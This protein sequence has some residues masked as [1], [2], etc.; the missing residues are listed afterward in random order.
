MK[1]IMS[2]RYTLFVLAFALSF[3]TAQA[4]YPEFSTTIPNGGQKGTELKLTVT[5]KNLEDF[6]SLMFFSPGFTQKSTD[7][8]EK[9]KVQVTIAIAADVPSGNHLIRIRTK[10]GISHGRRLFVGPF[11]NVEEKEPNTEFEAAQVIQLNQT[12][13]GV[14][15][16]EDVDYYKVTVKKGQRISVE[17]D[18]LCLGYT[19][20]DPYIAIIDKDRFEKAFSDDTILHRQDG[21]CSFV[22]E[23]DGDYYVMMR[24]S[25]YRGGGNNYYRLHVGSFRRP[26][27]VYPAG[28]KLGSAT[29]VRFIEKDGTFEEDA[30][31][32]AEADP[33]FMIYSKTQEAAPSGNP[34]RLV[35]FDNVLEVEPNE[36]QA[37]ATISAIGEP[38]ALNGIIEKPGDVDYF[39]VQL[40]KDQQVVLQTFAQSLGSPLD[41]VVN[42]YNAKGSGL[43]GN[44][45]GGGRRRLDSKQTLKVPADGDYYVRVT[46][47]LERGGPNFVYRIEMVASQ[48]DITFASPNYS[49]NDSNYRQFM[50]V[51][52]G[53]RMALLENFT[54]SNVSGDFKF[55]APGLPP[56][57]KML[58]DVIPKDQPGMPLVFEAASDAPLGHAVVA[59][60]LKPVDPAQ[61]IVGKM[62]QDFDIVRQGNTIFL[63]D[64]E[65]KL[66]VAVVEEAPYSLEIVKPSVPLVN[67]GIVNLKVVA[68]RKDGFKTAIRVLM[69]W[70]PSGVS[71]LGEQ[72]IPEGQNECT[73]VLDANANAPAGTWKF[74][75][76]GEADAGN[77]RIFNASPF[78]EVTTAPAFV[79]A[80][81]IPLTAVE[82]G[83]ETLMV[84]K[85]ETL[86]PFQGE[87][88]AQVVGVPET[89]P[90]ESAKIT[91]DTKEVSFK[92]KTTDK[93]PIGKQNNLFVQVEVPVP[94]GTTTHRIALG[95]V[96]RIDA[97][98]KVVTPPA[99]APVVAAN[100]PKEEAKPAAPKVLSRLEQL[101]LEAAAGK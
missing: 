54:R 85:L 36:D 95:S 28:A 47:H 37:K 25:S 33:G 18:G 71:T 23:Y 15:L 68:K 8:V 55:E 77:G 64:I 84:A 76:M 63:T 101:R 74:V 80:P 50:A 29:K 14:V 17:T 5:G 97:P 87:A 61:K 58:S 88:V 89:I 11:P 62:R 59:M 9:N 7:K 51:P 12:V 86:Q 79:S 48:P 21:Y 26:D 98:R 73:F 91:K 60:Q 13:E 43:G 78:C 96:L 1:L 34:F 2:P 65:D 35:P 32:P 40:K 56:G 24:E 72:T 39:K 31:I 44:D 41:S 53:G 45:D 66:P 16:S 38:I 52:R 99:A 30:Q 57:I 100:K 75:V 3:P 70:K 19:P 27:V 93:S 10:S 92:V 4:A 83:K 94:G 82:Q 49:V 20:F 6:E 42:V 81:A 90:I 69:V 22:A 46:D 67:N